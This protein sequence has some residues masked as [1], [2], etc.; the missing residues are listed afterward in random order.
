[1]IKAKSEKTAKKTKISEILAFNIKSLKRKDI[2]FIWDVT[3]KTVHNWLLAGCPRS[4]DETYDLSSVIKWRESSL[5][6]EP[7]D[8]K[9]KQEILKL[10]NQNRKLELDIQEKE[11]RTMPRDKVEEI[12]HTQA[13]ELRNF[14]TSG[15]KR[16]AELMMRA[17]GVP[18]TKKMEF[19]TVWDDYVKQAMDAFLE[20][21]VTF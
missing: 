5:K 14:L 10:Q 15:Y 6:V 8:E 21:G 4:D 20:S 3:P 7:D 9:L 19:L 12:M 1:M 2:A 11:R 17:L 13:Q 16:N 18:G